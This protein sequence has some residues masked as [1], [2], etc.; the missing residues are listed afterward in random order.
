M[1]IS[2]RILTTFQLLLFI[3]FPSSFWFIFVYFT[4]EYQV[5]MRSFYDQ[6]SAEPYLPKPIISEV[7]NSIVKFKSYKTPEVIA[8]FLNSLNMISKR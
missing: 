5:E 4:I 2:Y 8:Y 3:L 1:I 7:L 6:E